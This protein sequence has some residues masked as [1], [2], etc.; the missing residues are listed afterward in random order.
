MGKGDHRRVEKL[1]AITENYDKLDWNND[2][3]PA[4]PVKRFKHDPWTGEMV[5]I[6]ASEAPTE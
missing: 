3:T 5:E 2:K 4:P 1:S 6:E